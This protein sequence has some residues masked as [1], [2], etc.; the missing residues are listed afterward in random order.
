M[1]EVVIVGAKRSAI[2]SFGGSLKD[3]HPSDLGALVL[4]GA[5]RESGVS[6]QEIDEVIAG[7][8]LGAGLGQNLARQIAIKAGAKESSSAFCVNHVCGSGMKALQLAFYSI[9]LGNSRV[10]GV[11]GVEVMSAAPYILDNPR[12]GYKMGDKKICDTLIHDGLWCALE[13]YHMSITAENLAQQYNISR[14]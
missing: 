12:F 9:A 8:V 14:E 4:Q 3:I 13:G 1:K 5:L 7:N 6:A 2:G 10:V 11:G